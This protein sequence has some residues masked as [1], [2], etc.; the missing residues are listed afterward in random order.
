M[1]SEVRV[2]QIQNRSGLGTVTFN[3]S[4][5]SIAGVTTVG[6]LS[7]TGNSVFSGSVTATT[8][9]GALTGNVTGN[10]TGLSG[11]PNITVGN[12]IA[13]S[14]TIS[15]NVSVAGT[16]TYEDVTNVDSV[17][18]VTARTG[19]RINAGGLVVT[20]GVSTFTSGPVFIGAATSTGT[21][22]QPLQVTGGAYVSGNLGVGSTNPSSKLQVV[23]DTRVSGVVTAF[24]FYNDAEYPNVRP[25]LDLAFAQT[26]V[27]DSRITFSRGSTATYFDANGVLQSAATNTARFD[28]NPATGESLGLLVEEARTNLRT[29][30][31]APYTSGGSGLIWSL[32]QLAPDNTMTA[33]KIADDT[34]TG[35]HWIQIGEYPTMAAG[36]YTISVFA[37]AA[38]RNR[39]SIKGVNLTSVTF[40]LSSVSVIS[41]SGGAITA[42][43]NG[44]HKCSVSETTATPNFYQWFVNLNTNAGSGFQSYAGDGSSGVFIWG[45][46]V[47]AGAFPTSYIPTPA[48]FTGRA[49]F[50]TFYNSS[51]IIQIAAAGVSRSAAFFPD[52]NGVMRPAGLLLEAAGTNLHTYS[53]Q[54]DNA[55]WSKYGVTVTSNA[56]AAPDG[57]TTADKFASTAGAALLALQQAVTRVA[58][59]VYTVSI[60]AKAA[61]IS[62]LTLQIG[63]TTEGTVLVAAN[64]S[65]GT[66]TNNGVMTKLPNGWYRVSRTFT[67]DSGTTGDFYL[68]L[69]NSTVA[70]SGIFLWGAQLEASPYATSYI[71]TL[72]STVTRSADT[73]TSATVTRSADVASITG[74]NFSSWY[75]QSEGAF[76]AASKLL[77]FSNFAFS[78]SAN[79][80]DGYIDAPHRRQTSTVFYSVLHGPPGNSNQVLIVSQV[81][82]IT[83]PSKAANTYKTNDYAYCLD[84]GTVFTDNSFNLPSPNNLSVGNQGG[85]YFL[86]GTLSRFTYWPI[87][88]SN[89]VL[90]TITL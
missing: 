28:H 86:N 68:L 66:A 77:G 89:N 54:F 27:L 81:T 9:S 78:A 62:S 3:D 8:F 52:S 83:S 67:Q 55:A 37:K 59:T 15:G 41:G 57:A 53:E 35:Q 43:G 20:A 34:S 90:Q 4:G 39:F 56:V 64:L 87:R 85:T 2:N 25:T 36:T 58:S 14:A 40:D 47:E 18:L 16:L 32:N 76:F 65:T 71:P 10:A 49:S 44:W 24:D 73:S 72:A 7:A 6:I 75:N 46:Q 51:G 69:P 38:G 11:T 88:L 84:G 29:Y 48:T 42:L 63:N 5:V 30:S 21:A 26:K 17:G 31:N 1:A 33:V 79:G 22:S 70:G 60:F 45:W 61:E 19:V 50:A 23:G 12:I 82:N 13:S 74:T 80:S